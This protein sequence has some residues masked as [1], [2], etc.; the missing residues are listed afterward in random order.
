MKFVRFGS[1]G[2]ERPGLIDGAG[3][4]RD[5]SA[6]VSDID[7]HL[8][9]ASQLAKLHEIDPSE[10]PLVEG[11]PRLGPCVAGVRKIV[12][13]GL[14][15][16]DH[17][18][19]SKMPVPTEPILFL[20]PSSS[21]CGPFD[22]V[23]IPRGSQKTDWE[24]ELGVVIG[25]RA[26]YVSEAEAMNY[27]AGYCVVNDV[28]ERAFQLERLGQWDKGKAH[29]TFAPIGPWFVTKDEIPDPQN[30]ALWLDV[31]G[32][33]YQAGNTANMVFGVE[34]LIAYISNFMTLEPGDII[35]T[36]T[37]AGVGMGQTPP[38]YLKPGDEIRLGINGLGEQ[39]QTCVGL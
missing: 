25:R 10:L 2:A 20:K 4:L 19:E 3:A 5:L 35:S 7:L 8:F 12:C 16:T 1:A 27:V 17:A 39:A 15:Y 6:I 34:A 18:A 37:P 29:D 26:K 22:D 33:R 28:S 11:S 21:I 23:E 9:N 31:N 24:V 38:K 14:N 30:L 13:V 32:H 36:G